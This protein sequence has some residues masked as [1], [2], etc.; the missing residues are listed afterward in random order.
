MDWVK[1][2]LAE[3]W[4]ILGDVSTA[5]WSVVVAFAALAF[6]I[7]NYWKLRIRDRR[8][9]LEARHEYRL[10]AKSSFRTGHR[11]V[12]VNHGPSV[13]R[14]VH[15]DLDVSD[16]EHGASVETEAHGNAP[17]KPQDL[18]PIP[19]LHPGQSYYYH[20]QY[21]DARAER[22]SLTWKDQRLRRQ[23]LDVYLSIDYG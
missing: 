15:V 1:D 8:A 18:H 9:S 17:D 12:I 4:D 16:I 6:S 20:L 10:S 21:I 11:L 3:A 19:V 7:Y 13:A 14:N 5:G 22:A 2:R 23:T